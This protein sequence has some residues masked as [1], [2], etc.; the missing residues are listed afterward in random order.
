MG[1]NRDNEIGIRIC[2][3][4]GCKTRGNEIEMGLMSICGDVL[5][6]PSWG[7]TALLY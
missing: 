5:L 4:L 6:F 3:D 1:E 7:R 2:V